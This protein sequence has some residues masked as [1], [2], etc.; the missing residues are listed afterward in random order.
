MTRVLCLKCN[1]YLV[2]LNYD[3]HLSFM[4]YD[5]GFSYL[6]PP[7]PIAILMVDFNDLLLREAT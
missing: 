5:R 1:F 2:T 6:S 4:N 3:F 7:H